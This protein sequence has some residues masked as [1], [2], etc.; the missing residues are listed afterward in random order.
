[1]GKWGAERQAFDVGRAQAS[2][3]GRNEFWWLTAPLLIII[4]E[5]FQW[6][7]VPKLR[8]HVILKISMCFDYYRHLYHINFKINLIDDLYLS[9]SF[10]IIQGLFTFS[11]DSLLSLLREK[12]MAV[13][14]FIPWTQL[15]YSCKNFESINILPFYSLE[16]TLHS[17]INSMSILWKS[18]FQYSF[19]SNWKYCWL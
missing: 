6:N 1:M 7:R 2:S 14:F 16:Y 10:L 8:S 17:V 19:S 18:L 3:G 13:Y 11:K 9:F 4:Q 12:H 15:E 5:W